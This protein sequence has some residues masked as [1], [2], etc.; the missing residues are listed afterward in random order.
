MPRNNR[1]KFDHGGFRRRQQDDLPKKSKEKEK[2]L[3]ACILPT[4]CIKGLL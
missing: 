1:R 4:G 2:Q 3:K